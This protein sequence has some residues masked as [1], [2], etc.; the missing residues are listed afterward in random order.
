VKAE[1]QSKDDRDIFQRFH[2]A[3]TGRGP[4]NKLTAAGVVTG[5]GTEVLNQL[6]IGSLTL[7]VIDLSVGGACALGNIGNRTYRWA[8]GRK[9]PVVTPTDTE[10]V[11]EAFPSASAEDLGG[12][13]EGQFAA[14]WAT[15]KGLNPPMKRQYFEDLYSQYKAGR[16]KGNKAA[17]EMNMLLIV[18]DKEG[19]IQLQPAS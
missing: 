10:R 13:D 7:T 16:F 4:A 12:G 2:D 19:R 15:A 9:K 3:C 1:G 5:A 6:L 11:A 14:L 8:K 17:R 18:A